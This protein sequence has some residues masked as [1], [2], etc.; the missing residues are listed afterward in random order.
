MKKKCK[1]NQN[2][3]IE[4]TASERAWR[5]NNFDCTMLNAS[6]TLHVIFNADGLSSKKSSNKKVFSAMSQT[7]IKNEVLRSIKLTPEHKARDD[8][9]S[10]TFIVL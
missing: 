10:E 3:H 9:L 1:Q 8:Q 6:W 4:R 5:K 2:F 7:S